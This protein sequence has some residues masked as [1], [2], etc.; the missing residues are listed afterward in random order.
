MS[1]VL[2][3]FLIIIVA[4]IGAV[5]FK[6]FYVHATTA[7]KIVSVETDRVRSAA[8]DL[9]QGLLLR[10]T[11]LSWKTVPHNS[12]P[13]GAI[14][15]APGNTADFKGSVL[16]HAVTANTTILPADTLSPSSP[17]FL[18][19][20][21]QPGMRAVSV[22]IDDVSGNA[23]LIQ[24]GDFIDLLLTQEID[25]NAS[26][27]TGHTYAS[28]TVVSR[29][30]VLAVGSE[31][32]RPKR[33][34]EANTRARTVTLEVYPQT[35]EVIAVASRLGSLSLALRSF[36]VSDRSPADGS[37]AAPDH[38]L[39]PVYS[40][41]ISRV[42]PPPTV[43][44]KSIMVYRGSESSP[45]TQNAFSGSSTMPSAL[46]GLAGLPGNQVEAIKPPLPVPT[47]SISASQT[48]V[49]PK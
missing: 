33:D 28:E 10:E 45:S 49:S 5:L 14:V 19:A 7:P 41:Q 27:G 20:A 47:P 40:N 31:F 29:V 17:G 21:L 42:Q 46:A 18:A 48:G 11:D 37:A 4:A 23:G 24:T 2:R 9:P 16:R 26:G 44:E 3:I 39:L 12:A 22:G 38:P 25:N 8:A 36:A 35:A 13:S 6:V 43:A 30:R 32:Q 1:N 15:D 34:S